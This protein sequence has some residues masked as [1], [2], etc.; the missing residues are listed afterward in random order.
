LDATEFYEKMGK[1]NH[2]RLFCCH[3]IQN[4]VT[5]KNLNLNHKWLSP[6]WRKP[7]WFWSMAKLVDIGTELVRQIYG[8]RFPQRILRNA[9]SFVNVVQHRRGFGRL[10]MNKR[11][12]GRPREDRIFV[13]KDE[14]LHR[15]STRRLAN[16]LRVSQTMAGILSIVFDVSFYSF[17]HN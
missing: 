16:H 10:E 6:T 11:D 5:L 12:L 14:I 1:K 13:A 15:T 4:E 8:E 17:T 7:I 9:R 3:L 2:S